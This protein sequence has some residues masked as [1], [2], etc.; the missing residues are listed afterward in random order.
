MANTFDHETLATMR[1]VLEE[2]AQE[3]NSS[4]ATQAKMAETIMRKAA[5]GDVSRD[6]LKDI[7]IDAGTK[8]A[9]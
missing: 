8:P 9:P 3:L 7:A 4:Q 5:E 1:A 6:E 2:A